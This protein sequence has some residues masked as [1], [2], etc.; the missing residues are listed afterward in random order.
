MSTSRT[1]R[2]AR[3]V[4]LAIGLALGLASAVPAAAA[5]A[6][7]TTPTKRPNIVLVV[8]DDWG[9][10]DVGAYGSEIATPNLDALATAGTRFASFHVSSECSPTRAMLHTGVDNHRAGVGAMRETVPWSHYGKPGYLTVLD[11]SVVTLASLLQDG[12]YRTYAVGKWHLGKEAHN[13][14][15]ARGFG[16]SLV[17]ADSGSDN[18]DPRQRYLGLTDKVHWYEHDREARM[19]REYYSS[20]FFVDRA[21]DW[22]AADAARPEPFFLYVAFQANHIPLQAPPE[23]IAPYR[24]RYDGGWERLREERRDR[25]AALGLIPAGAPLV[26]QTADWDALSPQD[27]AHYARRMEVYAGMASAMDAELG[28]IIALLRATGEYERTVFVFLSDNGAEASDPYEII[29][30]RMWLATQYTRD[31]DRLGGPGAYTAVGEGWAGAS[32]SPLATWKFYAGEGGLRVPLI[33]AGVPGA[34]AGGIIKSFAH[35]TDITPTLLEVAGV[36][37]PPSTYRGRPVATPT[38]HSLL[39]VLRGETARVRA[40]GETLGYELAGNAALFR[41]DLKLVRNRPPVGDGRWRLFDIAADPGETQDLAAA[42]PQDYAAMQVAWERWARDNGVLPMP[43]G[44][45]PRRQVLLNALRFVYL[46]MLA[47]LLPALALLGG[48]WF[49]WRRRRRA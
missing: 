22:L 48:A 29:A 47:W 41:D 21:L 11:R 26:P 14:P 6:T 3:A 7:T 33:V 40:P 44:Y 16:R 2:A 5:P 25:A 20:R 32:A 15:G 18:W 38:G 8:A 12:G 13:L 42:R 9:Y 35:V 28:R 39:P 23:A 36:A 10:S 19:P 30:A 24:G 17:Q 43:E 27:R 46:P 45:E 4:L 1:E 49:L 34:Q 37:P 31:L